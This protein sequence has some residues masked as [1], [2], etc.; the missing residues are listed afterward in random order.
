MNET[1]PIAHLDF[2]DL[3][4]T[5]AETLERVSEILPILGRHAVRSARD[6]DLARES[7]DALIDSG[8]L[9]IFAPR[10]A[11]GLEAGYRTYLEVT[12]LLARACGASAWFSFILNHADWQV[13]QMGEAV[14]KAVWR[15]DARDKVAAPLAPSPGWQAARRDGGTV[16]R[17]EWPYTSGASFARWALVGFPALGDDGRPRD[18]IVGLIS[19]E[20][21]E[22]RDTW[23]VAGMAATGS[24]TLVL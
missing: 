9:R 8:A 5:R 18:T 13:G 2:P 21:V 23:H 6:R 10:R 14:Q 16:L 24:N 20:G 7:F 3:E 11:G 12:I 1:T 19:M 22:V 4:A 15:S 17:G